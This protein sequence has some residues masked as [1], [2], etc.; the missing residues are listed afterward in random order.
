MITSN[1][2]NLLEFVEKLKS[3]MTN[4]D[5][6]VRSD[7]FEL[8]EKVIM[9][10]PAACFSELEAEQVAKYCSS[11]FLLQT[12]RTR[13]LLAALHYL[14]THFSIKLE[15]LKDIILSLL[16]KRIVISSLQL[17][18]SRV[19]A[20]ILEYLNRSQ[21]GSD[22]SEIANELLKSADGE[23][24]PR[25]L[26]LLFKIGEVLAEKF[27]LGPVREDLFQFMEFYSPVT[28]K[29]PSYNPCG[30]TRENLETSL[31]LCLT[32]SDWL[33][34]YVF[35]NICTYVN[36][37][38]GFKE[39]DDC[40]NLLNT[41]LH[42]FSRQAIRPYGERILNFLVP[43]ILWPT[44]REDG[45]SEWFTV[46][47]Q[48]VEVMFFNDDG[49]LSED[50]TK[51]L[52]FLTAD[53]QKFYGCPE[54]GS[55]R[56]THQM[57]ILAA[58]RTANSFWFLLNWAADRIFE[59]FQM[60]ESNR[61]D[62]AEV[63][64][65]WCQKLKDQG[66]ATVEGME[67]VRR[68]KIF[69]KEN[70]L[71]SDESV[72]NDVGVAVSVNLAFSFSN[73]FDEDDAV[74]ISLALMDVISN[75][76]PQYSRNCLNWFGL[77]AKKFWPLLEKTI[78]PLLTEKYDVGLVELNVV[79]PMMAASKE[80]AQFV[81]LLLTRRIMSAS[82]ET[83]C[84]AILP[85]VKD[86]LNAIDFNCASDFQEFCR[87]I[88]AF[89]ISNLD[90]TLLNENGG[91]EDQVG[92]A[93]AYGKLMQDMFLAAPTSLSQWFLNEVVAMASG[94]K[95]TFFQS[96]LCLYVFAPV[97]CA[98]TAAD[99]VTHEEF[100]LS[101]WKIEP[102]HIQPTE[103][104]QWC[105][106]HILF[107]CLAHNIDSGSLLDEI[108]CHW[109]NRCEELFHQCSKCYAELGY[110]ARAL[111][112]RNH[113]VGNALLE[114]FFAHLRLTNGNEVVEALQIVYTSPSDAANNECYRKL[115]PFYIERIAGYS[116]QLLR[117]LFQELTSSRREGKLMERACEVFALL[118]AYAPNSVAVS[119]F[120]FVAPMLA[121]LKSAKESVRNVAVEFFNRL[122]AT[123][124]SFLNGESQ[125]QLTEICEALVS[126]CS[127]NSHAL[128][129][130]RVF[131]CL[132]RMSLAYGSEFQKSFRCKLVKAIVPFLSHKKRLVRQA[133][134]EAVNA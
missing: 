2:I 124:N 79:P 55:L 37:S 12:A 81:L 51:F 84:M 47:N 105:R 7:A 114:K 134:A 115:A 112:L 32:A 72:L 28:Y 15:L 13:P 119:D 90:K 16:K 131:A 102:C 56:M 59:S 42:R 43:L 21:K 4:E 111:L 53:L 70:L 61:R 23:A 101:L 87:I 52:Q 77:V 96:S 30:I 66:T 1:R 17:E 8:L 78:Y 45:E 11:V 33:A 44:K 129:C 46:Y 106:C 97:I 117:P 29:P 75:G 35:G 94:R 60:A 126:C 20:I 122:L 130:S 67:T 123:E 49:S 118:W 36:P 71:A 133:A 104:K 73:L 48:L 98:A 103:C 5:A 6:N 85:F 31:N 121:A 86:I 18:R 34:E 64:L 132:Q 3:A 92:V 83:E 65:D 93:N 63:L 108:L 82:S 54:L 100:L 68:I 89:A 41:A 116:L 50:W 14:V 125:A 58:S 107:S 120:Q 91:S 22:E 19:Y 76:S 38:L 10:L 99:L 80:A 110:L 74:T 57:L 39:K 69:A 128:F 24:D 9:R 127:E 62:Y 95:D 25:C 88:F 40:L 109:A 27:E 26:I 113:P